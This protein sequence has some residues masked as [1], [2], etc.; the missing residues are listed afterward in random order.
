MAQALDIPLLTIVSPLGHSAIANPVS[1]PRYRFIDT[2]HQ[3]PQQ[4][5]LA[6]QHQLSML[7]DEVTQPHGKP[8]E[9]TPDLMPVR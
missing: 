6:V 7:W 4:E 5:V 8:E 1:H 3:D 9:P 2:N